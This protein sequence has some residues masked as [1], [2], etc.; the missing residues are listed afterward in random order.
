MRRRLLLAGAAALAGPAPAA[1]QLDRVLRGLG[2]RRLDDARIGDGLREALRV[3]A[4]RAVELTGRLDGYFANQAIRIL[5]P[6][7]L[8]GLESGLRA[9][10]VGAQVDEFVLSMNRAAERAAP[11]ARGIFVE[12]IGAMSFD[13]VRRIWNG[14]DDAATRFFQGATAEPLAAAF[15]PVID[16]TMDEVGV[17]RQDKDL[18]ARFQALPFVRVGT[19]DLDAY[20]TGKAL[21]GLFHVLAEQER[22]I[23]R[24]PA[25]RTT[26]LLREV[27]AR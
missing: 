9:V 13:D 5:M 20:V 18:V 12:A 7:R 1:A 14:P 21:D 19:V 16:R 11:A 22:Q 27:F 6:E 10:G 4:E 24:S 25:A 26:E 17:T 2:G 15:R 23:R 8:R 3:G